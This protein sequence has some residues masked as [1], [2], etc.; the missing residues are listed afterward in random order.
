M[1]SFVVA[2][3]V[4]L[5]T[6]L[7]GAMTFPPRTLELQRRARSPT[8]SASAPFSYHRLDHIVLRCKNMNETLKFYLDILGATPEWLGRFDGTL[9]HIRVGDS[10]IDLIAHDCELAFAKG[11][12][13]AALSTLDHFALRADY[14]AD[15]AERWFHDHD[16][17]VVTSGIRFGS[18]GSGHSIYVKDP[19]GNT[20]ELKAGTLE[21]GES[22]IEVD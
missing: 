17:P 19:E 10:L 16:V 3:L 15:E 7:C 1:K 18:D 13:V 6:P 5:C 12:S 9:H 21:D 11:D 14:C 4:V 20:V 8:A 22:L 2:A